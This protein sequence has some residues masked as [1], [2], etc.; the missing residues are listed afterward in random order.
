MARRP[1]PWWQVALIVLLLPLILGRKRW[2]FSLARLAFYHFGGDRRFNPLA[3]M[4]QPFRRTRTFR[5]WEPFRDFKH[6][7]PEAL[8]ALGKQFF[9]ITGIQNRDEPA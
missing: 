7:R 4:F 9:T 3:V 6:G 5:F 2:S 8:H 1:T